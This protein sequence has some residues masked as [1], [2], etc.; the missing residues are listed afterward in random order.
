MS[1]NDQQTNMAKKEKIY[2]YNE[3]IKIEYYIFKNM[4]IKNLVSL[5]WWEKEDRIGGHPSQ[6]DLCLNPN[7]KKYIVLCVDH[8]VMNGLIANTFWW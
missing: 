2:Y 3:T 5:V 6:W 7:K 8:W 4:Q 1:L